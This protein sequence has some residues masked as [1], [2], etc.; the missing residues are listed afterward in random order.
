MS[1]AQFL[2]ILVARWKLILGIML[3]CTAVAT[4]VVMLLPKRYPASARVMLDLVKPDPVTG[5]S[6]TGRDVRGYVRTQVEL[7]KDM[8]VAGEV[9][10]KLG[11]A[12][13]PQ[14]IAADEKSGRSEADGGIR[15]RLGQQ[16]ID[17]TDANLVQGS[18]ILEIQYQASDP[19]YAKQVVGEIRDAFVNSSLRFRTDNA[20]RNSVWFNE[21]AEK[22]RVDLQAS[23]AQL[24]QFMEKNQVVIVGGVD[25]DTAKL[26]QLQ[27][28]LQTARGQQSVADSAVAARTGS[29]P[30]ADQLRLQLAQLEDELSLAAS[31]LGTEHP[32]YKAL[33]HRRNTLQRQIQ[34]A[35]SASSTSV[36]AMASAARGSVSQLEREVTQQQQVVLNR[37]PIIDELVRLNRDV[38]LKRSQYERAASRTADLKLEAAGSE[39]GLVVLGD[40]T[41]ER[42]P[43][44]PKVAPTILLAALFGLG[45]GILTAV[46]AEFI[47][48]RVRGP[49][50]LAQ[51]AGVPVLVTVGSQTPSPFRLRLQK[52]LGR[53]DPAGGDGELQAI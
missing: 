8:R 50:D 6:Q 35:Q 27:A 49:E 2:R 28:A 44:Y 11:L 52:L 29:D 39:T 15:A 41:V 12:N 53:R 36:T 26:Q 10:D 23:E 30:V 33:L 7:I 16:I 19:D 18:N 21:Q 24:A 17:G 31:K 3:A 51:A 20:A 42:T 45:L 38:E 46:V 32:N 5:Q 22:A 14:N 25:G 13:N 1:I 4:A 47:A 9:V 40:P 37:K 34:L 48:R 43:S